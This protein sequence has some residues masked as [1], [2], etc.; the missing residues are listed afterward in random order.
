MK[1]T[2]T[3]QSKDFDSFKSFEKSVAKQ[4]G[5]NVY[6]GANSLCLYFDYPPELVTELRPKYTPNASQEELFVVELESS[7]PQ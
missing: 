2:L 3:F 4:L 7:K 5:N 6:V 1:L